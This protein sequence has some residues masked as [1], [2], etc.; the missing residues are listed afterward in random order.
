[1]VVAEAP[2][3]TVSFQIERQRKREDK[4]TLRR[5][6][7]LTKHGGDVYA[8]HRDKQEKSNNPPFVKATLLFRSLLLAG[9]CNS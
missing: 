9:E 1:M 6:V 8:P 7:E 5:Y 4:G 2:E 3:T